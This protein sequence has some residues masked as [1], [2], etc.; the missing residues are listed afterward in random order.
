[1]DADWHLRRGLVLWNGNPYGLIL[2][3]NDPPLGQ[4]LLTLPMAALSCSDLS[5]PI[6][7]R[8]WTPGTDVPGELT[9]DPSIA[10]RQRAWRYSVLLGHKLSPEAL[11]AWIT[12]WKTLLMA[13]VV[14]A[15]LFWLRALAGWRAMLPMWL[16]LAGEPSWLAHTGAIALDG[17]GA[18]AGLL[19]AFALWRWYRRG[20]WAAAGWAGAFLA[21][22]LSIKHTNVVLLAPAAVVAIHRGLHAGRAGHTRSGPSA[23]LRTL[24]AFTVWVWFCLWAC[25]GF[26]FSYPSDEVL[27]ARDFGH[28]VNIRLPAGRYFGCLL[29]AIQTGRHGYTS[30]M[31]G[32]VLPQGAW[33]VIPVT[34][35]YKLP[36]GELLLLACGLALALYQ[37][38]RLGAT[39]V[40]MLVIAGLGIALVMKGGMYHGVRHLLLTL[41]LTVMTAVAVVSRARRGWI[42]ATSLAGLAMLEGAIIHPFELSF[43]NRPMEKPWA[44]VGDSNMD[45]GQQGV[46]IRKWMASLPEPKPLVWAALRGES[47][48]PS[49]RWWLGTEIRPLDVRKTPPT[50]GWVALPPAYESGQG[51]D[52]DRFAAFRPQRP[53]HVI[54]NAMGVYQFTPTEAAPTS[55]PSVQP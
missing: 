45:W 55:Q 13:P 20:G 37:R 47:T 5:A 40:A 17:L 14:A 35:W 29:S 22:A 11:V 10:S 34:A 16:I 28:I 46:A 49:C 27:A 26:N 39:E 8:H 1:M 21:V 38:I 4:F 19:S 7:K 6:D 23:V 15:I 42:V 48:L 31:L 24:L 9:T 43:V 41:L 52:Y 33:W 12:G 2:Q 18:G 32:H 51:D 36:W 53:Q 3:R 44:V 54:A 25:D 30:Y 50:S